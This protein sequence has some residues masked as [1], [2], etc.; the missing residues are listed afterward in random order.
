MTE[1]AVER[2][3]IEVHQKA[4]SINLR[5]RKYGTF[6]EIG[7]GQEV[8]RWFFRVGGA[9][10]TIAKSMS[11]YDMTVSDAIYGPS[12][13]YVSKQRLLAM[14]DHEYPLLLER[15][16][17]KRGAE[18]E[19]FAFADTVSAVSYKGGTDSHGWM[20][21][22]FQTHPGSESS[23]ILIHIRMLDS[24]NPAQQEAL[25][26]IGVNLIYGAFN[27]Y[28]TPERLMQS[29]LDG[30]SID[31][32][33]V[34][35]IKLVGP[36]FPNVDHRLL[37]LMLVKLGLSNAAMFSATGEVLQPSEILRKKPV[38]V[39]RGSFRPPTL[40]NMDI[41]ESA[42]RQF[43]QN[44]KFEGE[45]PVTLMEL[46]M[47]N[48]MAE[49][50]IDYADFLARADCLAATGAT[51]LIS[52]YFEFY[53]LAA[54]LS[55]FTSQPIGIAM[56]APSLKELFDEKYYQHLEGGILESFG[57]L[58]KN[59]LKLLIYPYMDPATGHL[60]TV[61]KLKPAA[62]LQ[63]LYEH[64]VENSYIE[65]LDFYNRDCLPILSRDVLKKIKDDD[66]T[67]EAMVPKGVA[68]IIKDRKLFGYH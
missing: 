42:L 25:G 50:E 67:W 12:Q 56:G 10:G 51:V 62:H 59:D 29:L 16:S 44:P 48:L 14:L 64:L 41:L 37:S 13:R 36:A 63:N 40:A 19:F 27:Y 8:V 21:V 4:L 26:V 24:N 15:L 53:R 2:E 30:L 9:A 23:D 20:G 58:F 11:A 57:R 68:E 7:A 5:K 22:R 52:N 60:V 38:L 32:I 33:E 66:P 47:K 34:D 45:E 55:R 6:A 1:R 17:E 65:S 54:Y 61:Q 35:M 18:T 3:L 28:S 39:E 43:S 31:R 46:T 49:G